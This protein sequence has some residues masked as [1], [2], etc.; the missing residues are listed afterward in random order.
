MQIQC[1]H[2]AGL[3]PGRS[4]GGG[5]D[6]ATGVSDAGRRGSRPGRD[7]Q[8]AEDGDRPAGVA[9]RGDQRARERNVG[10]PEGVRSTLLV[11]LYDLTAE[12]VVHGPALIECAGSV[13]AIPPRWSCRRV[14]ADSLLWE[15][16]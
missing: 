1:R 5:D 7:A 6:V 9:P 12:E 10:W 2:N 3:R 13:H 11:D 16:S 15:H 14:D 8:D 4:S